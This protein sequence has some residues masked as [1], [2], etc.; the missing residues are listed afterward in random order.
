MIIV[1]KRG[2]GGGETAGLQKTGAKKP[3]S[4]SHG[5]HSDGD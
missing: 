4:L 2:R 3:V 1:T 5:G